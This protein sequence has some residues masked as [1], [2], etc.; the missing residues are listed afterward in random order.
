MKHMGRALIVGTIVVGALGAA[1]ASASASPRIGRSRH[2]GDSRATVGVHFDE[3]ALGS[4]H[5]IH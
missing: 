2:S 1:S 4:V 3:H 5:R